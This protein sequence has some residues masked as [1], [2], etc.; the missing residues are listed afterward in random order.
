MVKLIT[1]PT[2]R[3]S[4]KLAPPKSGPAIFA[5]DI[6]F[7]IAEE[8][9]F[10]FTTLQQA[11]QFA[12]PQTLY[13]DNSVNP[14][15]IEVNVSDTGQFLVCPPFSVGYFFIFTQENSVVSI[16]SDGGV[17]NGEKCYAAFYTLAIPP[18]VWN[19][20]APLVDGARVTLIGVDGVTNMSATNPIIVGGST[21]AP[22][23][24]PVPFKVDSSGRLEVIGSSAGGVAFGPDAPGANPTQAPLQ[25]SGVD[26]VSGLVRRLSTDANGV[27]RT[28]VISAATG[29]ASIQVQGAGAANAAAVGNP[30]RVGALFTST[31]PTLTNG[32][33]GNLHVTNRG[34]LVTSL[35]TANGVAY[36]DRSLAADNLTAPANTLLSAVSSVSW[37]GTSFDRTRQINAPTADLRSGLGVQ[38]FGGLGQFLTTPYTLTNNQ[39]GQLQITSAGD[40]KVAVQGTPNVAVTNTP[41]V[42]Q[43]RPANSTLSAVTVLAATT[44]VLA[45]N[46]NRRGFMIWN[47]SA[48][49]VN[50][51]LGAGAT[52][53]VYTFILA[54]GGYY[55]SDSPSVYT[56]TITAFASSSSALRVTE[57]KS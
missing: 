57:I 51:A 29:S 42:N 8:Y 34:C 7:A 13:L 12:A 40:L 49:A 25:M 4:K 50:I 3:G 23:N 20:F 32:W 30:L 27:L 41:N 37:N 11:E 22:S 45:A 16:K 17:L 44:T 52:G 35:F 47:A 43:V 36:P 14:K 15:E 31:L 10:D 38:A 33:T 26:N 48:N 18:A 46:S 39:Y 1:N 6:D 56:G 2:F 9:I 24:T 28:T 54:A 55:E 21:G 53:T 19:G 5:A